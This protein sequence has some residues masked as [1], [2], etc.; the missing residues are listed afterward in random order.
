[1][2]GTIGGR[3][4][5]LIT[6]AL[7]AVAVIGVPAAATAAPSSGA[8]AA[9][10]ST[11]PLPHDDPFYDVPADA[12][13]H[14]PGA[15]LN[16]R[17]V[18]LPLLT[19]LGHG[20]AY[21]VQ[22][23][24]TDQDGT[25]TAAVETILTPALPWTGSG[26][27]P[28]M[29]VLPAYDAHG[30]QCDPSYTLRADQLPDVAGI[31]DTVAFA[32]GWDIAMVDYEGPHTQT[33]E[34]RL[35]ADATLDAAR[36]TASYAPV[37]ASLANPIAISGYSGGGYAA[38][39][40]A[41]AQPAYAPELHLVGV[42]MGGVPADWGV[43]LGNLSGGAFS[44]LIPW[45]IAGMVTAFPDEDIAQYLTPAAWASVQADAANCINDASGTAPAFTSIQQ[46]EAYPGSLTGG[47][48]AELLA[49][50]SAVDVAGTP[51]APVYD[52]HAIADEVAPISGD[53]ALMRRYCA[54]GATVDYVPVLG[55]HLT[56][57]VTGY[58][59]QLL[60][61]QQRFAGAAPVN[62][63]ASIPAP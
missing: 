41:Q 63:C 31:P 17:E 56:G 48:F 36:A 1:M 40:A 47:R 13:A 23:R 44:S 4:V 27:R 49:S 6:A 55:E 22:F 42:A 7:A 35:M 34:P 38:A 21:Q 3:T 24:T 57:A 62:D 26:P 18:T 46:M 39:L 15:V 54:A 51:T 19:E 28:I 25:A 60:F 33:L 2:S 45:F 58:P 20:H 59:G 11:V 50:V 29:Y 8:A 43:A 5:A 37:G 12:A 32:Q 9:A 16:S 53:Q 14:A 10:S 30:D 61:L 52:Y